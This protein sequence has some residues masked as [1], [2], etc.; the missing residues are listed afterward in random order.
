MVF[1]CP[2]DLRMCTAYGSFIVNVFL[3][4]VCFLIVAV[5]H[6]SD[7]GHKAVEQSVGCRVDW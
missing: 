2:F 1:C 7:S 5:Y 6:G 4:F 3:P